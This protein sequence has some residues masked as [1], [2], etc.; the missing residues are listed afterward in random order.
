M[1]DYP[2]CPKCQVGVVQ[3]TYLVI[4]DKTIS[5]HGC[6]KCDYGYGIEVNL[7]D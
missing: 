1:N 4:E 7:N 5:H 6:N 3:Q 2:K